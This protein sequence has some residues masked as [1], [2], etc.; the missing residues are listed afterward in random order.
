MASPETV[1]KQLLNNIL[2]LNIANK[3]RW[4]T[5]SHAIHQ[6]RFKV[7]DAPEYGI[8][9]LRY[10]DVSDI[11]PSSVL[12][13]DEDRNTLLT[14]RYEIYILFNDLHNMLP[15]IFT[16]LEQQYIEVLLCNCV[17]KR[18]ALLNIGKQLSKGWEN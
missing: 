16:P 10:I 4:Y 8:E 9:E 15:S 13:H 1:L 12:K 14:L 6:D 2:Y 3:L 17:D 7:W 11:V 5:L 18:A